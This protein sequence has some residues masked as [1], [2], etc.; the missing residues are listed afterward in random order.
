[1][2]N[3]MSK[4]VKL[5]SYNLHKQELFGVFSNFYEYKEVLGPKNL[6]IAAIDFREGAGLFIRMPSHV[7]ICRY[8]FLNLFTFFQRGVPQSPDFVLCRPCHTPLLLPVWGS[9]LRGL[10]D[11][12]LQRAL[13]VP[14]QDGRRTRGRCGGSLSVGSLLFLCSVQ[15]SPL[16]HLL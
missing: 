8:I 14:C 2:I 4:M 11:L 9:W 5:G 15:Q 7:I 10:S 1:M 6:R 16:L 12:S 3:L 13:S